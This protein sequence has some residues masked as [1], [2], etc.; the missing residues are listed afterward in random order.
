MTGR[1]SLTPGVYRGP[2]SAAGAARGLT[3]SGWRVAV[4]RPARSTA[5]LYAALAEALELPSWSGSNLDALWDQ[6]TELSGPTALVLDGWST[7]T[8][9]EPRQAR[10]MLALFRERVLQNPP[11]VVWRPED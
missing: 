4:V 2:G 11:F 3:D 1:P 10:R 8:R 6:L 7:F 5:D 9:D